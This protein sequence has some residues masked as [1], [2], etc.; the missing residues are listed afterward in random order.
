[1]QQ[2]EQGRAPTTEASVSGGFL[3]RNSLPCTPRALAVSTVR[4][5]THRGLQLSSQSL[6]FVPAFDS[7]R[8]RQMSPSARASNAVFESIQSPTPK[9]TGIRWPGREADHSSPPNAEAKDAWSCASTPLYEEGKARLTCRKSPS[10]GPAV[11]TDHF[12]DV[13]IG[14]V[15]A[16]GCKHQAQRACTAYRS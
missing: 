3:N 14:P 9:K 7:L 11:V 6:S 2:K 8:L 12:L 15:A 1:V 16:F 5:V 4:D 10:A 13:R